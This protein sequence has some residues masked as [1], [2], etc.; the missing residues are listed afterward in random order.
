MSSWKYVMLID[1]LTIKI[2][3][4]ALYSQVKPASQQLHPLKLSK[5][6]GLLH[7]ALYLHHNIYPFASVFVSPFQAISG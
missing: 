4:Q 7:Q 2:S 5:A 3:V 1:Q 6:L